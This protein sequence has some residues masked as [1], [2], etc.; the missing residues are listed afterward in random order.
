MAA[1][2]MEPLA[3]DGGMRRRRKDGS[4]MAA[5][6]AR[7]IAPND[8]LTAFERLEIYNVQYWLRLLASLRED[9]P[10]LE[11][12]LGEAAFARLAR[13]YLERHPSRSFTLRNLGARLE[14]FV[15]R[16]PRWLG[17]G[18]RA[19][20]AREVIRF[21]WAQVVA[22]DGAAR[23][24][25]T[26]A[27]L[28]A[29]AAAPARLRLRLQ[30]YLSLLALAYPV[31]AFVERFQQTRDQEERLRSAASQAMEPAAP[32]P[33]TRPPVL[34]PKPE[35]TFLAV[36]RVDHLLYV[37]RLE[38]EAFRLLSALERGLP[39]ARACAAAFPALP[40]SAARRE[41]ELARRAAFLQES[42]RL[43]AELG[44][45]ALP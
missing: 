23:P 45:L 22:F 24:T 6:A 27:Q 25:P 3:A 29:A 11:A 33:R 30:P 38:P 21:E 4:A 8:R 2:V 17:K 28:A 35:A 9:F 40:R 19:R 12:V 20:F 1:S 31:D 13:A 34:M 16:Q 39:L 7:V 36:H 41:A 42:F 5:H 10:I 18:G 44:W 37:K 15:R 14:A 26:P 43:W 32:S